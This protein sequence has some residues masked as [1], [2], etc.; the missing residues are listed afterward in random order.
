MMLGILLA[1]AHHLAGDDDEALVPLHEA[2]VLAERA[3]FVRPFVDE[4]AP[5]QR[6]IALAQ[7]QGML[8]HFTQQIL[9]VFPA[10]DGALAQ[11]SSTP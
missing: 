2:L 10:T 1:W 5:L 7:G 8:P 11:P 3:G 4:G 9:A 6:L